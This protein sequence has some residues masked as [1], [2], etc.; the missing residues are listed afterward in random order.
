MKTIL[1]PTDFSERSEYAF[2]LAVDLAERFKAKLVLFYVIPQEQTRF[3]REIMVENKFTIPGF[4]EEELIERRKAKMLKEFEKLFPDYKKRG[5]DVR[6]EVVVGNP[7]ES[8]LNTVK[9]YDIDH[10]VMGTHGRTGINLAL[11]GSV[12]EKVV[13]HSPV[14]VTTVKIPGF[15]LETR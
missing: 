3:T 5:I 9:D 11:I 2:N 4:S 8:I 14:P 12:A 1:A 13:R 7:V 10:I 6:P 15:R